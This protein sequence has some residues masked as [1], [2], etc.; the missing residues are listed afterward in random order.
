MSGKSEFP[1]DPETFL[2]RARLAFVPRGSVVTYSHA[3]R[4]VVNFAQP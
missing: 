3:P 4:T 1:L 2:N